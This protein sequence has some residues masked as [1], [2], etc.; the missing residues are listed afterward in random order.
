MYIL[1]TVDKGVVCT[2]PCYNSTDLWLPKLQDIMVAKGLVAS[3]IFNILRCYFDYT[4]NDI[5]NAEDAVVV[6]K[7]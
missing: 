6:M 7:C 1:S 3:F 5:M 2:Q 4:L